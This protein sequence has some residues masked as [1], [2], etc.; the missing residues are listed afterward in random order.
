MQYLSQRDNRWASHKIGVSSL[1]IGRYGCTL[2]DIS[3]LSD[4]FHCYLTPLEI[5]EHT[6]WFTKDGLV[7]WNKLDFKNLTFVER[8]YG[9]NDAKIREALSD[10]K[11]AVIFEVD[12]FHWLVGIKRSGNDYIVVDPWDGK[13][14]KLTSAYKLI[15]GCAFFKGN[16]N[17]QQ[18]AIG[19]QEPVIAKG[20]IKVESKPEIWVYNGRT[21]H[22]IPDMETGDLLF[23]SG[24][25]AR[26]QTITE[27][28]MARIET[29]AE[30]PSLK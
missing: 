10:P 21:R 8:T 12:H 19:A 24:W 5:A 9:R 30:L 3:M 1:L 6:D 4:Y 18:D 23:G 16:P 28:E 2:T 7:L 25:E 29:G 20:L 11:Q 17:W 15:T 22:W 26:V 13:K 27:T 14:K